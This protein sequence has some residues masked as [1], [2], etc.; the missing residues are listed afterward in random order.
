MNQ[1]EI[2]LRMYDIVGDDK[3]NYMERDNQS[4]RKHVENLRVYGEDINIEFPY[5]VVKVNGNTVGQIVKYYKNSKVL[6][7]HLK[8]ID[9]EEYIYWFKY[10]LDILKELI[11]SQILGSLSS[12]VGETKN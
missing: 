11:D 12:S 1:S 5:G 7:E 10:V 3:V 4:I 8:E 9:G 6:W 2:L